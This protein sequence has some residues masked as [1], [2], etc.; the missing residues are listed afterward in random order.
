M[1]SAHY[2]IIP[3]GN[4]CSSHIHH[5][6]ITHVDVHQCAGQSPP[7]GARKTLK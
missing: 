3:S 6:F 2:H 4:M 5:T 1:I 7:Y